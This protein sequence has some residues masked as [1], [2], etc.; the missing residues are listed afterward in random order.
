MEI[1]VG[2]FKRTLIGA[3]I[4]QG[5]VGQVLA[6][7]SGTLRNAH[8][9]FM[10]RGLKDASKLLQSA[11][12]PFAQREHSS[13]STGSGAGHLRDRVSVVAD[14]DSK[15]TP[16]VEVLGDLP[17]RSRGATARKQ[18]RESQ[19][20]RRRR[21]FTSRR[22]LV[23]SPPSCPLGICDGGAVSLRVAGVGVGSTRF[24]ALARV[25]DDAVAGTKPVQGIGQEAGK[26]G[27]PSLTRGG[28]SKPVGVVA[29]EES[30]PAGVSAGPAV[31]PARGVPGVPC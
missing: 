31:T 2:G 5:R 1:K 23:L 4:V 26:T 16:W 10:P 12:P 17:H 11:G 29:V 8:Q 15:E 30:L 3:H 6:P 28:G 19:V 7:Q 22:G 13:V 20:S 14:A 21:G 9:K 25:L 18:I 27:S 24:L